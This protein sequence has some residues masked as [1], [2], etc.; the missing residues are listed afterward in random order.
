[1][2]LGSAL[3]HF[4]EMREHFAEGRA[5]LEKLLKLPATA[6][7]KMRA[8]LLFYAAIFAIALGDFGSAQKLQEESLKV[9]RNL[10]D[11]GGV[12]VALNAL[13]VTARDRGDLD[14]ACSLFEQCVATWRGLGSSIDTAR[15]LSNLANVVR[16]RG[17]HAR[18]HALYDECLAIFHATGDSTGVAW[19][20]NYLG[21]LV[22]ESVDSI[23]AR[24]YYE[25][26]LS[27]F[28]QL[29]DGWGIAST[30]CDLARLSAA[31]GQHQHAAQLYGESIKI[32]Q[33]LGHKRGIARVLEC[34]AVSAAAQSR[35]QHALHLAGAA[36]ALRQRIG[37]PLIPA[38]QSRLEKKLEPAQHAHERRRLGSMVVR[39]GVSRGSGPRS[40]P[41]TLPSPDQ[42]SARV[43]PRCRGQSFGVP[44]PPDSPGTRHVAH[45]RE[46]FP[47]PVPG[48]RNRLY[49]QSHSCA[50]IRSSDPCP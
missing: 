46:W 50:A 27:A 42:E 28:R 32:F 5:L 4:W 25:Q 44:L 15:A 8:R 2:R 19:T 1:M 16:L 22:R 9:C 41:R 18:V 23:A 48:T 30:V 39:L 45:A 11:R 49:R 29:G 17:D 40:A 20:L 10:D 31:D 38:E 14:T 37:A 7:P 12:A 6:Q 47:R 35:P 24:S 34:L 43:N 13:G 33:D 3:F 21:D 26:S 36:A